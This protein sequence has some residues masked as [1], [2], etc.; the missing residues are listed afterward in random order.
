ELANAAYAQ[1]KYQNAI[2]Q[3]ERVQKCEQRGGFPFSPQDKLKLSRCYA[4]TGMQRRS[5]FV[6][7]ELLRKEE[8]HGNPELLSELF[9]WLANVY[10]KTSGAERIRLSRL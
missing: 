3:Y 6:C 7:E 4:L 8:V 9:A 5:R 10:D 2:T 1:Q